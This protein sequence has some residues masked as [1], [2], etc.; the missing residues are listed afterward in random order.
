MK[1]ILAIALCVVVM[2]A[3]AILG[4]S[5]ATALTAPVVTLTDKTLSWTA[6]TKAAT[7]DV[8]SGDSLIATV[9]STSIDLSNYLTKSGTYFITVVA[10]P[11]KTDAE[12]LKS[13]PSTTVSLQVS[14]DGFIKQ[15]L[16]EVGD[17]VGEFVPSV[18]GA[19]VSTFDVIFINPDTGEM[20][21]LGVLIIC[22]IVLGVGFG[23][24]KW[25]KH[26]AKV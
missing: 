6:V 17:G 20:T 5:A 16:G 13:A 23:I 9:S 7:Y 2:A 22:A 21:I 25:I 1:K 12:S 24:W 10:Q 14:G 15:I 11:S 18:A 8:Y 19:A 4:I 26:R 3:F